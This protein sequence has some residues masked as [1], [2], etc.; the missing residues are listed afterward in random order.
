M[1]SRTSRTKLADHDSSRSSKSARFDSPTAKNRRPRTGSH[2]SPAGFP[3]PWGLLTCESPFNHRNRREDSLRRLACGLLLYG[4]SGLRHA[5]A[6]HQ[7]SVLRCLRG[8]QRR[9]V[10]NGRRTVAGVHA[11]VHMAGH[12]TASSRPCDRRP[13]D[14]ALGLVRTCVSHRVLHAHQY[15]RVAVCRDLSDT[16]RAVLLDRYRSA[17]TLVRRPPDDVDTD[18]M[19][20]RGLRA[21]LSGDQRHAARQPA[22]NPHIRGPVPDNHPDRWIAPARVAA[23]SDPCNRSAGLGGD[24]R[25][26][27]SSHGRRR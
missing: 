13:A 14:G 27:G 5:T 9:A 21:G 10:A 23:E 18:R 8:L 26:G 19:D 12:V 1:T 24:W 6:L 4:S 16:G 25:I 3:A 22:E 2:G 20:P 7:R 15:S 11:D 17:T